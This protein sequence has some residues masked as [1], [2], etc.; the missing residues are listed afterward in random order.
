MSSVERF[1]VK[2]QGLGCDSD[3]RGVFYIALIRIQ[4]AGMV[5]L[6]VFCSRHNDTAS[7][8]YGARWLLAFSM[9]NKI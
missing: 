2:Y 8:T 5:L 1:G 3:G 6:P 7:L 9:V 4:D